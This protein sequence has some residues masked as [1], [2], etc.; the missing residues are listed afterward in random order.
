MSADMIICSPRWG[1][2]VGAIRIKS[3]DWSDSDTLLLEKS[4]GK[5]LYRFKSQKFWAM[6]RYKNF[7]AKKWIGKAI[8]SFQTPE[9]SKVKR[10]KYFYAKKFEL[11][12][13]L[14]RFK[15]RIF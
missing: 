4:I 5:A 3:V 6:K 2:K 12:K 14:Y 13:R 10:Y 9:F 11:A 1:P 15:P 7:Y 8:V